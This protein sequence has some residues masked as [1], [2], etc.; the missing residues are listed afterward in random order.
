MST[1]AFG[2]LLRHLR[3]QSKLSLRELGEQADLDHAYIYR[4]E[5]G[6]KIAPSADVTDRL[7][8][9][10]QL[11]TRDREILEYVADRSETDPRFAELAAEDPS[12]S[13]DEFFAAAGAAFRGRARP[14]PRI[15]IERARRMLR[16]EVDD[17]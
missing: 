12:I 14:E 17:G 4:L 8:R 13:S 10:L 2:I 15:M 11:T 1:T 9:A 16:D 7:A 5:K 3:G 6:D